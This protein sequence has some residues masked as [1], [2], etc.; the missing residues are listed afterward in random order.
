MEILHLAHLADWERALRA[1]RY[2]ISTRGR[3]L[4]EVGFIH[5][6][7][8]DQVAGVAEAIYA[9]DDAELCVLV[10][11]DARIRDADVRMVFEDGGDGTLYPHIYGP[12]DPSWVTEVRPAHF[13]DHGRL[14][15]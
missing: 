7:L 8:R 12:I 6:A 5:A 11:D 4:D 1:G 2:R 15:F 9:D 10:M 13:D 3:T 14:V